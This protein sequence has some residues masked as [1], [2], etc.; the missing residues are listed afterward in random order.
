MIAHASS[1]VRD[2]P[3]T[4]REAPLGRCVSRPSVRTIPIESD[5]PLSK[6]AQLD[7]YVATMIAE[8]RRL[9]RFSE[10]GAS[11][12]TKLQPLSLLAEVLGTTDIPGSLDLISTLLDILN[13]VGRSDLCW[14]P[15]DTSYVCQM[16]MAAIE[17]S[18]SHGEHFPLMTRF[19]HFTGYQG[20]LAMPIRLDVL[21]RASQ[22]LVKSYLARSATTQLIC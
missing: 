16:L 8:A 20:P 14:G 19:H 2:I 6:R 12:L 13:K 18:A 1:A 10:L 7:Q 15:S 4:P 22:G 3:T 11:E 21:G 17:K 9:T 5:T